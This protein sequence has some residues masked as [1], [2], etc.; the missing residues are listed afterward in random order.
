MGD[1]EVFAVTIPEPCGRRAVRC[2]RFNIG[3]VEHGLRNSQRKL[4]LPG[5]SYYPTSTLGV[6]RCAYDTLG[7][8]HRRL[9]VL[10]RVFCGRCRS[11]SGKAP[12]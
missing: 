9:D 8:S 4:W 10:S 1:R 7:C 3:D 2:P 5:E 12:N 6:V 11:C